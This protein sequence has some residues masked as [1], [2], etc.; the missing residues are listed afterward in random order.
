VIT[1]PEGDRVEEFGQ[2]IGRATNN[3]AEYQA[4]LAGLRRAL[5]LGAKELEVHADSLLVV[6]QVEGAWRVKDAGL[7]PLRAEARELLDGLGSWHIRHVRRERNADADKLVNE[8]L[9]A[10]TA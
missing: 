6:R 8:A 4:L 2:S 9:D 10:A 3:V 5:E 1:T 7:R